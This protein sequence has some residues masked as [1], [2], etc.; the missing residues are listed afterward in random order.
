MKTLVTGSAGLIGSS[1]VDTLISRKK[2][3]YGIDNLSL[4]T[5]FNI[6]NRALTTFKRL[7]LLDKEATKKYIKEL[8]PEIIFHCAAWAHEGLA[9]FSPTLI[10]ENSINT[11]LNVI[12]PAIRNG[13]KHIVVFSSMAVY[14]D[15]T[16]P[17]TEDMFKKPVDIYAACKAYMEDTTKV[18]AKVHEFTYTIL[19]PY[20][21]YG[22]RQS[23][24]D[25]YRGVVA[26]FINNFMKGNP[27]SV[28]GDGLQKRMYTYI[29]DIV[30]YIAD[31]AF[32]KE[33]INEIFNIGDE[34]VR[35]IKELIETIEEVSGLKV[36]II[37]LEERAQEVKFAY[38][39]NSKI[40]KALGLE[41][42]TPFKTAIANTWEYMKRMGPT[43]LKYLKDFELP[44]PKIPKNWI[45]ETKK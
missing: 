5:T 7:D 24:T 23:L 34:R 28:Y 17:F 32:K 16:P 36:P 27:I 45:N 21:V 10:T 26:L 12:V 3:V 8:K 15:Q 41:I 4:S 22:E 39:D 2:E 20:N 43:E 44:S 33:T 18:L 42:K 6:S 29:G 31:C 37:H 14:G 19:R 1:I 30:P 9:Q 13:L 11:F 35:T 25:P 38:S 40:K